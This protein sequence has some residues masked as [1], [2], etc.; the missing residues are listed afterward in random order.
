MRWRVQRLV[1]FVQPGLDG[2]DTRM[3]W[4]MRRHALTV[5]P[6]LDEMRGAMSRHVGWLAMG[7][8]P[9][10]LWGDAGIAHR[11]E[12]RGGGHPCQMNAS[13]DTCAFWRLTA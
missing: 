9:A 4:P 10:C 13:T 11:W 3:R 7:K 2:E 6:G 8:T 5:Q 1:S 12:T